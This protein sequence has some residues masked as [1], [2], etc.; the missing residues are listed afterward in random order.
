MIEIRLAWSILGRENLIDVPT[1]A[2]LWCPDIHQNRLDLTIIVESG[3]EAYGPETQ[4]IEE[5][6]M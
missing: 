2:G 4:W 6:E 1:Q 5:R 3:N